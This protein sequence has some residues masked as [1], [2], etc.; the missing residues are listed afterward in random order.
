MGNRLCAKVVTEAFQEGSYSAT[1]NVRSAGAA[2]ATEARFDKAWQHLR[3][4]GELKGD[5]SDVG[6]LMRELNRDMTEENEE[7]LKAALWPK[8][9]KQ[10]LEDSSKGAADYFLERIDDAAD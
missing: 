1:D 7:E 5:R 8:I 9:W 4:A 10:I 2:F 3:D 6:R